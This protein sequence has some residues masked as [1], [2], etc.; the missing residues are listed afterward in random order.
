MLPLPLIWK[1]TYL[2]ISLNH[3]KQKEKKLVSSVPRPC[4]GI[5]PHQM[6]EEE[7]DQI[8]WFHSRVRMVELV[9]DGVPGSTHLLQHP[10][11]TRLHHTLR[12]HPLINR[13]KGQLAK[14]KEDGGV[15]GLPPLFYHWPVAGN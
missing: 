5:D 10:S 9:E 15:H 3:I 11:P 12:H 14:L 13:L 2:F 1:V 4:L 6:V 7:D 8:V